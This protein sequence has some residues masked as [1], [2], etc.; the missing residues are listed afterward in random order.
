L[1]MK[2]LLIF[3][4]SLQPLRKNISASDKLFLLFL[5]GPLHIAHNSILPAENVLTKSKLILKQFTS[6]VITQLERCKIAPSKL[7]ID[8]I[9]SA[10]SDLKKCN[11]RLN[12][13]TFISDIVNIINAL[14]LVEQLCLYFILLNL[15]SI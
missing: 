5:L 14:L 2:T 11:V 9:L 7:T 1:K 12:S 15:I 8:F 6:I 3:Q 4:T 10:V 13:S